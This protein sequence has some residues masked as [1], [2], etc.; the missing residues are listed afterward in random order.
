MFE[1][2]FMYNSNLS[3]SGFIMC[4]LIILIRGSVEG[5]V[6]GHRLGY[7]DISQ[8]QFLIAGI[9]I[10]LLFIMIVRLAI[11]MIGTGGV[12]L[13]I[14]GI[15]YAGMIIWCEKLLNRAIQQDKGKLGVVVL[16]SAIAMVVSFLVAGVFSLV[17]G[18]LLFMS[19]WGWF[20]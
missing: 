13:V 18:R 9:V 14:V 17:I 7:K 1:N 16:Y 6:I 3:I 8:K 15:K 5:I 2:Y 19:N 20:K 11:V 12:E 10:N 4:G